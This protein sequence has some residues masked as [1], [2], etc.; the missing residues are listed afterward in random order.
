MA[1][2]QMLRL[3]WL[4]LAISGAPRAAALGPGE[5]AGG[6]R[7]GRAARS[8][9]SRA[10]YVVLVWYR[11][12]DPLGTFQDQVYDVRKGEYSEAVDS[13]IKEIRTKYPA[14]QVLVRTVDLSRERGETEKLKVGSVIYRELMMAAAQS[15]VV[16]GAP[17]SI[18]P[19]PYAGPSQAPRIHRMP[20]PDRSFLNPSPNSLSLPVYPRTRPP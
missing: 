1:R 13:W 17:L 8:L 9:P 5:A 6:P 12:S 20:A 18:S 11:R 3:I 16:L 15:G 14:Y 2:P 4:V 7:S 10:D 19:G